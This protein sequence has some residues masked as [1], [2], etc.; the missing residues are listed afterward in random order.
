[1]ARALDDA[2]AS[3]ADAV[4]FGDLFLED[5]RRYREDRLRGTGLEPLFPLWGEPTGALVAR[6]LEAG[7]RARVTCVDPKQLPARL[8]GSEV[9]SSFVAALPA[10]VDPCGENGEFHTFAF[11]GPMFRRTVSVR[12]GDTVERDGFVFTDLL[13]A[14]EDG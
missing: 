9:D 5:V 10:S 11:A 7:L 6:M 14:G 4:A 8:C 12:V 13:P 2:R 1:M 3:G